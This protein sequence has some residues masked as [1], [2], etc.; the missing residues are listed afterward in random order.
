MLHDR[1][2]IL[3]AVYTFRGEPDGRQ[4]LLVD[5]T[6][7]LRMAPI[8]TKENLFARFQPAIDGGNSRRTLSSLS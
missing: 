1:Y 3:F 6:R 7:Q 4:G 8:W 2:M 5:R